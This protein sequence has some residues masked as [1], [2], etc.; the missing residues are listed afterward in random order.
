MPALEHWLWLSSA[1]NVSAK[2][3]ALL[4]KHY[5][6]AEAAYYAPDGEFLEI[7]G[8]N[9]AEAAIL[10]RR[11]RSRV[12]RIL[13]DC[14][15]QGIQIITMQDAAYP[16]RLKNIYLPPVV[17]YV[18]GV[19]PDVDENA[20]IAVIGTRKA[21]PYGLKMG[22]EMAYQISRCGGIVVSGLT[23]GVDEQAARGALIAGGKCVA[24]LGT[25]HEAENS[26]L[27]MDVAVSG[28]V[29]S[30]YPP[31]TEQQKNFFRERNRVAA[32]LSVGVVVVEA[33]ERSGTRLFAMEAIEQGKEIF[34]VPG[35][36]DA[37]NS[38]GTIALIKEGAK[39]VT[40]GAE[41]MG[42]FEGLYPDKIRLKSDESAPRDKRP[43]DIK[44]RT[45]KKQSV[46]ASPDKKSVDT[47]S[48]GGYIDL[49]AQLSTLTETQLKIITAIDKNASH[50]DDIIEATGLP[51][52]T[53]LAQLTLLEI[54][55]FVRREAGRRISLNTF[56][57]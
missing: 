11:D 22:R 8:I 52:A 39:L 33:P 12:S 25:P 24:V 54:K 41:V 4:I 53:V 42:E 26:R 43:P 34:A 51:T 10:E 45:P 55:G 38:A 28:A 2:T 36:A 35:N 44:D 37:E 21:S 40:D 19:L 31:G 23:S 15:Q 14:A 17:L 57:K 9:R 6:G 3:K 5:G 46:A 1:E 29:I 30:E 56:K 27:A 49:K 50:I 32:G 48:D 18:K 47:E 7:E 13:D 16:K 20:L